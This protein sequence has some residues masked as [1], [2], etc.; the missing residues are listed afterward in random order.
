MDTDV[1]ATAAQRPR[2]ALRQWQDLPGPRGL[3]WFGNALQIDASRMHLQLDAWA[4]EFGP[5]FK[6]RMGTRRLLVVGDH[7]LVASILRDRPGA[8]HR[9]TRF[10]EIWSEMGLGPNVFSANG[11]TWRRQRRMVMSG[12]DP[13]HVQRYFP[14]LLRVARRLSARWQRAAA[15]GASVDLQID[16]MRFTVDAIAGLAFGADVNTLESGEDVIQHHLDQIFPALSRRIT[17]AVP[18]WR[19][20]RRRVDRELEVAVVEVNAAV[21]RFIDQARA[22]LAA[23]ASRRKD[24]HNLLEAMVSAADN[25]D[26]GLDDEQ[27]AG[28]VV[29][30]LLAGEDTT[31]HTIAWMI[32][33]L[34]R[35]PAALDRAVLEVRTVVTDPGAITFE[36]LRQLDYVEACAHETMR[37]KPVAPILPLQAAEPMTVGGVQIEAGTIV[38]SLLR[39]DSVSDDH[40]ER[41]A[42]FEPERWMVQGGP[43]KL[44]TSAKRTSMPFGA[45]PRICPGRYLALLEIKLA[46]VVLLSE[47]DLVSVDTPDGPEPRERLSFT[48]APVGLRKRLRAR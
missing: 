34:W 39:R 10:E 48:M 43:G 5:L 13:A 18:T 25:P 32:H 33:L 16:L 15:A 24:P 31:A 23:D 36:Q 28:N 22:R 9:T 6:L 44:A 45:G 38:M 30:M 3:P 7:E 1:I 29:A 4:G 46:M 20:L 47:F 41:A 8:F 17:A 26:S 35:H 14:S 2:P 12:F 42:S 21:A 40:V 27:V 19:Y 37:L 11:D